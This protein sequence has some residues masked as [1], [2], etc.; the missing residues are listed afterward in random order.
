MEQRRNR[1]GTDME[2]RR[3]RGGTETE[4][5]L[6]I[7]GDGRNSLAALVTYTLESTSGDFFG[8]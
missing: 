4:Q 7:D 8:F 2:Q 6:N 1:D 3:N 5:R